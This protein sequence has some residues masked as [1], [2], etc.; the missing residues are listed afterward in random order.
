VAHAAV[1]GA[2]QRPDQLKA[3]W[4]ARRNFQRG[5]EARGCPGLRD[6]PP[7]A[8]PSGGTGRA[9]QGAK[10]DS[11]PICVRSFCASLSMPSLW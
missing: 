7:A 3:L 8:T 10:K 11:S 1:E 5:L 2:R 9:V 4:A 6:T